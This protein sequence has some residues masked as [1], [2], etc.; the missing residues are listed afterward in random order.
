[1]SKSSKSPKD[2][3]EATSLSGAEMDALLA[4][5]GGDDIEEESPQEKRSSSL[6]RKPSILL[7]GWL[8]WSG[9]LKNWHVG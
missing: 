2:Q 4:E 9:S 6:V 3:E 5:L 8:D 1:M 7:S